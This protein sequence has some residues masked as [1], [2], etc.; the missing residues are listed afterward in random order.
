MQIL[1]HLGRDIAEHPEKKEVDQLMED[2]RSDK[3][4]PVDVNMELRRIQQNIMKRKM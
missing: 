2:L 1:E 3:I 4:A